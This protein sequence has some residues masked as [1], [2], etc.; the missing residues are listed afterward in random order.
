MY[1]KIIH[2]SRSVKKEKIG[3]NLTWITSGFPRK[4]G[5]FFS[6]DAAGSS[7]NLFANILVFRKG[8]F[9]LIKN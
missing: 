7:L 5:I 4:N 9:F 1:F 8:Y 3:G 6:R 2:D